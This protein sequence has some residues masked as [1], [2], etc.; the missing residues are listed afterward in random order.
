MHGQWE[1]ELAWKFLTGQV[2]TYEADQEARKQAQHARWAVPGAREEQSRL[3]SGENNPQWGKPTSD[4]QKAA[5]SKALKGIP[6]PKKAALYRERYA[7][8]T[9]QVPVMCGADNPK[10]SPILVGDKR[11]VSVNAAA[12]GEGVS[13][14]TIRNRI[15]SKNFEHYSYE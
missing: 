12:V 11:Y 8:G 9:H 5:V 1:D 6:Q 15:L 4:L 7:A 13:R 10:S 2:N 3:V 14:V